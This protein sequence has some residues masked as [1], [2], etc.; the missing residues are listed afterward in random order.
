MNTPQIGNIVSAKS[1][2]G[3]SIYGEVVDV[4]KSYGDVNTP[5]CLVDVRCFGQHSGWVKVADAL[6]CKIEGQAA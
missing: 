4:R 5:R 1:C 3:E 2:N 6:D